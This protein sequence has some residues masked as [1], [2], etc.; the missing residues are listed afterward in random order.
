M[1]Y[2]ESFGQILSTTPLG[3]WLWDD[4]LK[5]FSDAL[6]SY[7]LKDLYKYR[8]D[9]AALLEEHAE[10]VSGSLELVAEKIPSLETALFA[11]FDTELRHC[12][13][14]MCEWFNYV[15]DWYEFE[16][17][18]VN[19]SLFELFVAT[20]TSSS[21][22]IV[23]LATLLTPGHMRI[24]EKQ[25]PVLMWKEVGISPHFS[26]Y[27][28]LSIGES[29]N[30]LII[31]LPFLLKN[32][33]SADTN[34]NAELLSLWESQLCLVLRKYIRSVLWWYAGDFTISLKQD[35][36]FGHWIAANKVF[37]NYRKAYL[38]KFGHQLRLNF[39][40]WRSDYFSL[41]Y[42]LDHDYVSHEW[43]AHA[44]LIFKDYLSQ[45]FTGKKRSGLFVVTWE[46]YSAPHH[47]ALRAARNINSY[48]P[49]K[50]GICY[51]WSEFSAMIGRA[52]REKTR[53]SSEG[54]S[55]DAS[56]KPVDD[57]FS[58]IHSHD[59]IVIDMADT[60]K[61]EYSLWVLN[62]FFSERWKTCILVYRDKSSLSNASVNWDF[63]SSLDRSYKAH[64]KNP[65]FED[66]LLILN[67]LLE[68]KFSTLSISDHWKDVIAHH[69]VD[70]GSYEPFLKQLSLRSQSSSSDWV[71]DVDSDMIVKILREFLPYMMN[72]SYDKILDIVSSLYSDIW[73]SRLPF[74]WSIQKAL[75]KIAI[76]IYTNRLDQYNRTCLWKTARTL[77]F[78]EVATVC[79]YSASTVRLYHNQIFSK[80]KNP[81]LHELLQEVERSLSHKV[82]LEISFSVFDRKR[83]EKRW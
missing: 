39:G 53:L 19:H 13:K 55:F 44:N 25:F 30:E 6:F 42:D 43:N 31:T 56:R 4:W 49:D 54:D 3:Q 18:D 59:I 51:T 9:L 15:S 27:F 63:S 67:S 70:L 1:N 11:L 78:K 36:S 72:L 58:D 74:T 52:F 82:D 61:T 10:H 26:K 71:V 81:A 32:D 14:H 22:E 46:Q 41:N 17:G 80:K 2:R 12:I 64:L 8:K 76:Y 37:R 5:V 23:S 66:R 65:W 79:G 20:E 21:L 62:K 75:E 69:L 35:G 28:S 45:F 34:W 68:S 77:P 50:K 83:K 48:F 47:F 60:L 24:V 38:K 57:L 40:G 33:H 73:R 7:T 16:D 29:S